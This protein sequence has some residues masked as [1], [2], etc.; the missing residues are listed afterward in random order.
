[1][2]KFLRRYGDVVFIASMIGAFALVGGL[3]LRQHYLSMQGWQTDFDSR[4]VT[5]GEV[6]VWQDREAVPPI[7]APYFIPGSQATVL[8]DDDPVIALEL[9]GEWRAY[10]LALLVTHHIVNDVMQGIPIA[11]TFC[12]LCNSALVFNRRVGDQTLTF[13]ISGA[14]RNGGFLMWDTETQSWWQQFTGEAIMGAH[15]G[16]RLETL[17]S[18]IVSWKAYR[19]WHPMGRVLQ[20]DEVLGPLEYAPHLLTTYEAIDP[21]AVMD[22]P[23][24]AR[25]PAKERVLGAMIGSQTIV[26]PFHT[27]GEAGL[28]N[29][30]VDGHAVVAFWQA[31]NVDA[32]NTVQPGVD[33]GMAVLFYRTVNGQTLT[34]VRRGANIE[35]AE[36]GSVWTIFGEAVE[37]PLK[38][39]HLEQ[40]E[41]MAAFW[42]AWVSSYPQ[43]HIYGQP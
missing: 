36:T 21:R 12:P 22:T 35:D 27:L 13:G 3:V 7:N 41:G 20:R 1:M 40:V 24:D 4:T 43:T 34:F 33:V 14:T 25:L 37:G 42:F 5:L 11:I 32:E 39:T 19:K 15:M 38:R 2:R 29:D 10:P 8:A 9:N 28:I 6:K 16:A 31:G 30:T 17:P 18:K 26:Y 23:I